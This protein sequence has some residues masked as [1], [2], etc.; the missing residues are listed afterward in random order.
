MSTGGFKQPDGTPCRVAADIQVNGR[1]DFLVKTGL[2]F[3]IKL[4]MSIWLKL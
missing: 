2:R 3:R 4:R 1:D